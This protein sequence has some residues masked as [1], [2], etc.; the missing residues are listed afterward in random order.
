MSNKFNKWQPFIY[1]LILSVGLLLGIF[2]RPTTS[3]QT[4]M[5]GNNKFSELLN[6]INQSYV[7][8]VNLEHLEEEAI[9]DLLKGLDPHSVYIPSS[10]LKL[11]NEQLEGNFEGIGVEFNI[12]EDTI[13]VVSA[14]NGG[15]AQEL[16][17]LPGDRIVKVDT[18]LVAGVGIT[19]EK[20][21][22]LLR[23]EGGTKVNVTI[24]RPSSKD[25]VVYKIT[26]GTIP[27]FS[28]DA[29]RMINNETGYIKISRFAENTH[30]EFLKAFDEL[31]RDNLKNLIIDLRGN[32]G[33]YLSTAIQLV[34]ELLDERKLI[35]Y[36]QGRSKPRAEYKAER[37]GVFEKGKL[38]VL[39]DEGSASASEIVSGAV[40]DWDRGMVI[41]RRSFGK[42]L[43]QEPYELRDGSALRL[44]VSRYYT[45]SG[46]CIQKDYTDKEKYE[47]DIMDRYENG[48]LQSDLKSAIHDST[49]YYTL[50]LKRTVF[51]GG[52]IN[53]D[54]F[55]PIDTSFSSFYLTE[56]VSNALIGKFAYEYLDQNRKA[57]TAIPSLKI[58]IDAY[59]INDAAFEQF[60]AFT[61]RNGIEVPTASDLSRSKEFIK[62]Q[63]KALIARQIW[64]DQGFYSV[65]QKQDKAILLALKKLNENQVLLNSGN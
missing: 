6:I 4:F 14:I 2:L 29:W 39:I 28:I 62:L 8:T 19:S 15:P 12:I 49:P 47:H 58:Y 37:P 52:G 48:E 31:K 1:G 32:P 61:K 16:G 3:K 54:Y 40:Q 13:M 21:F 60:I 41:G 43:V 20:V 17:V 53:P 25:P 24:F 33:G 5:G 23:G 46:R 64:R 42:G 26:R 9:N 65:I 27:I 35:V 55:V 50:R 30:D 57:I 56:V 38:I 10:E 36:T 11:A 63:L 18:L 51:A 45:P 44:T 22:K 59:Q 7:D 34:D